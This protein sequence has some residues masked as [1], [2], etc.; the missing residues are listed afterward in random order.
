MKLPKALPNLSQNLRS[1]S[2][3]AE[4][5][6]FEAGDTQEPHNQGQDKGNT[7]DQSKVKAAPKHDKFKKLERPPTPYSDVEI[8]N[9]TQ[10]HFVGPVINLLKGTC[11]SHVELE[12][13]I[14]ECYKDVTNRLDWNNPEG[15]EYPFDLSKP[16]P[17]MIII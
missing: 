16:L 5:T 15:K 8:D 9:L 4:E 3:Q 6:V 14:E 2:T 13:N 11:K 10:D 7:D 12:Y 1:K 17:L